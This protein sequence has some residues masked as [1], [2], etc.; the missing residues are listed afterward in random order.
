MTAIPP[1]AAPLLALVLWTGFWAGPGRAA[2]PAPLPRPVPVSI[3]VDPALEADLFA[4]PGIAEQTREALGRVQAGDLDGAGV[5]LDTL[6]TNHPRIGLLAANRATLHMLRGDFAAALASLEL[7]GANGFD[8]FADLAADPLFA[9]IA[10]APRFTRLLAAQTPAA[11]AAAPLV[12]PVTEGLAPVSGAN[13]SW[14]PAS[15]RLVTRFDFPY[16]TRAA[17]LPRHRDAANEILREH[18]SHGRAA[19]NSG[20]L[21]DN[22]DRGH[23]ALSPEAHPQL[24]HVTYPEAARAVDLDYG[25]NDFLLFG[26]PTLGNSST[27]LTGG[28]TWRSL[29]RYALTRPDG[30]GPM[31]LWQNASANQ[32]YIHPAHKDYG[33]EIGDL[34]PGNTPYLIVSHGSSGSDKPFLEAVAMIYAAYRPATKARLIEEG[35]LV[36]TTQMVFRRSL[37]NVQSRDD[38][39]SAAAHPAVFESYDINLARM[40]SLANSIKPGDIPPQVRIRVTAEDIATEGIDYFGQGL[41]EQL[42]DTPAAIARVWRSKAWSREITLSAEETGDPND[43]ALTFDW[44]LL[45][46]DPDHVRITPSKDGRTARIGFDWQEPFRISKDNPLTSS[47]VDIGVFANNGAHDSAPAILSVYFPPDQARVYE[48][49]PDGI[50]RIASIDYTARPEIY[51]DPTLIARAGWRDEYHYDAQG[52]PSGWTRI[53]G[54]DSTARA[55]EFTALGQRILTP[56]T[57]DQPARLETVAYPLRLLAGGGLGLEEISGPLQ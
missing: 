42:Y 14:D 47:R 41:S 57:D 3:S 13:T 12:T 24:A 51:A 18:Y 32:L 52:A 54:R 46:G 49:G 34:F 22:R 1:R 35:L 11:P 8:G 7:A 37:R 31:R 4:M 50:P 43:R 16:E 26:Q 55:E 17:V 28:A 27:A 36:P 44:R 20:D 15:E 56:A 40:V 19:G 9:P 6:A 23:S 25:L 2:D 38:Y 30:T 33:P 45:A 39:F 10:E 48:P 53:R 5:L 29:P 21:Y